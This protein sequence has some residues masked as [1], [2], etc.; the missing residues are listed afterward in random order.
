MAEGEIARLTSVLQ[1]HV[2]HNQ[3]SG[4]EPLRTTKASAVAAASSLRRST[5]DCAEPAGASR[6]SVA[7]MAATPESLTDSVSIRGLRIG[8]MH[9]FLSAIRQLYVVIIAV[10]Q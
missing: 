8:N 7:I 6:G 3:A 4:A 10:I 9:R 5:A 2:I 1:S